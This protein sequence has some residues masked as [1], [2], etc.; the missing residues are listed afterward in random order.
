MKPGRILLDTNCWLDY[1]LNRRNSGALIANLLDAI[2]AHG[3]IVVTATIIMKDTF[4]LIPASLKRMNPEQNADMK[5]LRQIAWECIRIMQRRTI[6]LADSPSTSLEA[7]ALRKY[8]DDFEDNL[9]IAL[10]QQNEVALLVSS[11]KDLLKHAP[12]AC[13]APEEALKLLKLG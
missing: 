7:T 5:A 6:A 3:S 2:E 1:F 13:L 10:A 12:I 9:I 4:Y 8:H 11:D